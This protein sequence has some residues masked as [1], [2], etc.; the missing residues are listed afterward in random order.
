MLVVD[1]PHDC[2]QFIEGTVRALEA[3]WSRFQADSDISRLNRHAG[4][5]QA[6]DP[7]TV[8]L[9]SKAI[10]A[11]RMTGGRYDPT[12]LASVVAAG[13][14]YSNDDP[15]ALLERPSRRPP[16]VGAGC[17]S[18]EIDR[19]RCT[20]LLPDGVGFDPGGI[21]KGLAADLAA[22]GAMTR[23]AQGALVNI[24]GDLRVTGRPV[25]GDGWL[26]AVEDPSAP[27]R[28]MAIV[29]IVD[30]GVATSNRFHAR[31]RVASGRIEHIVDPVTGAPPS[32]E[33]VSA[34][35]V[36]GTG[37]VAEAFSKAALLDGIDV[38]D[39]AGLEGL[40]VDRDGRLAISRRM[41]AF[42]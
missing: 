35:V 20:A 16:I 37:W 42:A 11:W 39:Q 9:L 8:E 40:V 7:V 14:R 19:K 13:Y 27:E 5:R 26:I 34:T 3:R 36:A 18:I 1:G 38:L 32:S 6:V 22:T 21:G 24:G 33:A 12:V 10:E 2:S 25:S 23:G 41:G 15:R 4:V 28:E 17:E 30:G 29:R 31:R